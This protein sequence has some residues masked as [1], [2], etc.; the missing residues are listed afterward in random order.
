M[1]YPSQNLVAIGS[2]LHNAGPDSGCKDRHRNGTPVQ[3][4]N[5]RG[6]CRI[7]TGRVLVMPVIVLGIPV[8]A[9][10]SGAARAATA[11]SHIR[12]GRTVTI[13]STIADSAMGVDTVRGA[14][15]G[16]RCGG[17]ATAA[18]GLCEDGGREQGCRKQGEGGDFERRFHTVFL[19][20]GFAHS[21]LVRSDV[22]NTP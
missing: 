18:D 17:S 4:W 2:V 15:V 21:V 13:G 5:R 8:A 19:C 22:A 6:P 14:A 16:V 12:S 20:D 3:R 11:R 9:D 7:R 1:R 10:G